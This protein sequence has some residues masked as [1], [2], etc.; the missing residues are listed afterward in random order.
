MTANHNPSGDN[1]ARCHPARAHVADGFCAQCFRR[2]RQPV[3][4]GF[5][6]LELHSVSR[7]LD[8]I[9]RRHSEPVLGS[10]RD[11]KQ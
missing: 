10:W 6:R 4:A 11:I 7:S 3:P 1:S 2:R 5:V 9:E 8:L